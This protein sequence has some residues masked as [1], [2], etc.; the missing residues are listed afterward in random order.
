MTA[1]WIP[2]LLHAGLWLFIALIATRMIEWYPKGCRDLFIAIGIDMAAVAIGQ[3]PNANQ[4]FVVMFWTSL[5]S[6][7]GLTQS[8][9]LVSLAATVFSIAF[10]CG[11]VYQ[12]IETFFEAGKA[13]EDLRYL[14]RSGT[15]RELIKQLDAPRSPRLTSATPTADDAL[16][17]RR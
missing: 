4:Q 15:D 13:A 5:L 17:D 11:A 12:V 8:S 14:Q 7:M 16:R 1:L 3:I 6:P 2:L 10:Q 9:P